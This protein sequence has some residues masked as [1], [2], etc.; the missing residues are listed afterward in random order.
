MTQNRN[1]IGQGPGKFGSQLQILQDQYGDQGR[2][3]LRL[4]RIGAGPEESLNLK[5]LFDRLEKQFDS[6]PVLWI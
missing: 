3:D 4:H 5:I 6:P 1:Q 2:P